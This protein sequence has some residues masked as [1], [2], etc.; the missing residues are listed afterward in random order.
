MILSNL[1]FY[2]PPKMLVNT[3]IVFCG[4][5]WQE[6]V[7]GSRLPN[8]TESHETHANTR[9]TLW[10][11]AFPFLKKKSGENF[12][13][14]WQSGNVSHYLLM[15]W[16]D[17]FVCIRTTGSFSDLLCSLEPYRSNALFPLYWQYICNPRST[18]IR[19][20]TASF[21]KCFDLSINLFG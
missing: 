8:K 13:S 21:Q 15:V 10:K 19:T 6:Q 14:I 9:Y 12:C 7:C 4:K 20:C 16:S 1:S 18:T 2:F 5:T 17:N 11:P 3:G